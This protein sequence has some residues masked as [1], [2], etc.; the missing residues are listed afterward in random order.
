ML[1]K[2]YILKKI[3]ESQEAL[4]ALKET[5]SKAGTICADMIT[6][7]EGELNAYQDILWKLEH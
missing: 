7:H 6:F 2:E 1:T 5:D 3:Q 4:E